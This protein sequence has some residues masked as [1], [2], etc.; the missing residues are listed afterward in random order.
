MHANFRMDISEIIVLRRA[1]P[2]QEY[3]DE[4]FG[5]DKVHNDEEYKEELRKMIASQL[6]SDTSYRFTIDARESLMKAAGEFPLPDEVLKAYLQEQHE[7]ET[8]VSI[9]E[10]YN[11]L[12]PGLR[13]QLVSDSVAK[14]LQLQLTEDDLRNVAEMACRNQFAQYGMQNVPEDMLKKYVGEMLQDRK[15]VDSLGRQ[16]MEMK[17]FNGI[18]A[19]AKVD[20]KTVSVEE[21][22]ALFKTASEVPAEPAE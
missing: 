22:N 17:L 7:A 13:W 4:V 21:F 12:V 11:K 19:K 18:R 5:K 6:A 20:E 3:Y 9:D 8:E 16:A 10:E 2:G 14:A 1:E 15:V